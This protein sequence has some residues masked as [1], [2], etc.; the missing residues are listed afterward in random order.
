MTHHP[1]NDSMFAEQNDF[2]RRA[3]QPFSII[4]SFSH[5]EFLYRSTDSAVATGDQ[6][7]N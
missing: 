5:G 2:T 1:M 7:M 6:K 3:N 4:S